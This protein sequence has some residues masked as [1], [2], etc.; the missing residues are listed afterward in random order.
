MYGSIELFYYVKRKQGTRF[1]YNGKFPSD[2]PSDVFWFKSQN[3]DNFL[4]S[5]LSSIPLWTLV[6]VLMLWC[7][8]NG[9]VHWL[10]WTDHPVYLAF[11]VLIAPMIHEVHFFL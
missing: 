11:L 4:R 10:N 3:F 9:W 5:F 1:K 7:F 6:E 2:N 8:A